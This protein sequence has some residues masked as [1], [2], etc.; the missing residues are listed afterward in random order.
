MAPFTHDF[1]KAQQRMPAIPVNIHYV[2]FTWQATDQADY[3]YEFQSLRSMD[4][5]IM[6]H[7]TVNLPLLGTVPHKP[8]VVQVGFPCLG[9]QD[10]VAAFEVTILVMDA[11]GNVILRTP[12]NAIF[13]KT[14]QRGTCPRP[15]SPGGGGSGVNPPVSP[16]TAALEQG[17]RPLHSKS[18]VGKA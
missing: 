14:C 5:D 17:S 4:R 12:H 13:F 18:I 16:P 9:E 1:R 8:S 2:N 15:P 11:G 6:D 7:P 3:F 10:G